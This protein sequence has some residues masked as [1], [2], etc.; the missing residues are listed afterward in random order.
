MTSMHPIAQK[1]YA[2]AQ[3][4]QQPQGGE[5]QQGEPADSNTVDAE[6]HEEDNK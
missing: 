5:A 3:A 2:K 4:A 1:A 6:F